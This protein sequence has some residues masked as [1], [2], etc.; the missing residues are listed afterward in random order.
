MPS[1][2][3]LLLHDGFSD[4]TSSNW[5]FTEGVSSEINIV[6]ESSNKSSTLA[7]FEISYSPTSSAVQMVAS[8]IIAIK[9]MHPLAIAN[10]T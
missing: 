3:S 4:I 2:S 7:K 8:P 9:L 6:S 5:I 1:S 10:G